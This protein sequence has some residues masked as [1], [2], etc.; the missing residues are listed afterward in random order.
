[1]KFLVGGGIKPLIRRLVPSQR[2]LARFPTDVG[3]DRRLAAEDLGS[4]HKPRKRLSNRYRHGIPVANVRL[5]VFEWAGAGYVGWEDLVRWGES[6]V[7]Y[8]V[9]EFAG[10]GPEGY[11]LR[12]RCCYGI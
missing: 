7:P 4:I 3:Q 2:L 6:F 12:C 11:F 1:M 9:A 10:E 5:E 8:H